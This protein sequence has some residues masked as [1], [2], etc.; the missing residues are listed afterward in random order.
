[1][2]DRDKWQE[3]W[4]TVQK[5][6]LRTFL[7]AFGVFWGI[8]M[9]IFMVGAGNGLQKGATSNF[10][11]FASNALYIWTRKTTLPYKG[12]QPGRTIQFTNKDVEA[13]R[14]NFPELD[15]LA[16]RLNLGSPTVNYKNENGSYEVRGEAPSFRRIQAKEMIL[17]RFINDSDIQN[18]RKVITIG[19]TVKE[20]LYKKEN[21]IGTYL[22]IQGVYF[23]VV[24]VF[25]DV[26]E[27]GRAQEEEQSIIMP[28]TTMQRVYNFGDR[29]FW[30]IC[31]LKPEYDAT[32]Y[33]PKIKALLAQIHNV[34]PEDRSAIGA[35]NT[36]AEFNKF[37]TIFMGIDFFIWFAGLFTMMA[38][39]IGVSN[40]MMIVVRERTKEIG[41]RKA[42]GAT[43]WS[44]ISLILQESI[45]LTLLSGYLGLLLGVGLVQGVAFAM[46]KFNI[47]TEFFLNPQIDMRVALGAV[48]LL[49]FT[50]ALAGFMPALNAAR[51]SPIEA[52][53]EE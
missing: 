22:K 8:F 16:P 39:I 44:V 31:T 20:Q 4:A 43:P 11:G 9:L 2:F 42:L 15:A 50:G 23:K 13:L 52:L 49:V 46:D 14:S 25:K 17:G 7:T 37:E 10:A 21:P 24:G 45:F 36:A 30:F 51:I 33:E 48:T 29:I 38:G 26:R 47:K 28:Y 34:N 32:I 1:M 40:I 18:R 19:K 53:R 35:W 6:K 3:I 12:F 5:N 41:I 27:G